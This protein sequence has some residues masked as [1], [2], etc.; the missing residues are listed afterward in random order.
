MLRSRA[1]VTVPPDLGAL[2]AALGVDDTS[3]T[4]WA[5]RLLLATDSHSKLTVFASL[6]SDDVIRDFEV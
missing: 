2:N 4:R 5:S 6:Y 3:M 1:P